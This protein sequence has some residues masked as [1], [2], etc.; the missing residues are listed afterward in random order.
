MAVL[1]DPD[2]VLCWLEY[3]R[4]TAN[5]NN[6]ASGLTKAQIRA[7]IDA[8]DQWNEDNAASFNSALPAAYRNA[9]TAKQKA[10]MQ[11]I[12]SLKRHGVL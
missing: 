3:M 9:A 4:D 7:A 6:G 10:I 5:I 12:V 8:T 11:A 2:R 1:S